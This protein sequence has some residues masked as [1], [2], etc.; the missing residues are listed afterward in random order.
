MLGR[1]SVK[2]G[3]SVA[4]D[5]GRIIAAPFVTASVFHEFAGEV[6]ATVSANGMGGPYDPSVGFTGMPY[7]WSGTGTLTASRVGTY[8]QFGIGS[9]FLF[10]DSGWLG[11]ARVDW[12]TGDN[13]EGIS[14]TAGL[15][16]QLNSDM[17]GLKDGGSLKDGPAETHSWTGPYLG[18]SA[19]G[20]KGN[21]PWSGADVLTGDRVSANPDFG[22]YLGSVQ[23]GYNR[24]EGRFV[25]GVEGS[26]GL[27]NARG[28]GNA[29]GADF[30]GFTYE[31]ELKELG[32]VTGRLGYTFGPALVYAKGGW[33]FGRVQEKQGWVP[34][35]SL[36][37]I[38]APDYQ[39][40]TKWASGWTVGG[41]MEYA[42]T[43]RW[44]AKAEYMHYELGR[45]TFDVLQ[46]NQAGVGPISATTKG[47][48][49]QVGINYHLPPAQ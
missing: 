15:R 7:V 29:P 36:G 43:D 22:G 35:L 32:T 49:V 18:V 31:D 4:L 37:Q 10:G 3:T 33:A 28:A 30:A 14:G 34:A 13:I 23:A 40:V 21:T 25:V 39:A 27:S 5:G 11:F 47:D 44:S 42:L 6:K 26:Y 38:G 20:V 24:Q 41:G 8:G 17:A 16:Y 48:S 2:L 12:R 19:G 45:R 9:S 46:D 1:A